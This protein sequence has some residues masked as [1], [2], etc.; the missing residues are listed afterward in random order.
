MRVNEGK[1]RHRLES[2]LIFSISEDFVN[3]IKDDPSKPSL[4]KN[5]PDVAVGL[6]SHTKT[7]IEMNECAPERC[8]VLK[9]L[10]GKVNNPSRWIEVG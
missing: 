2:I 6:L 8:G 4:S 1:L 7:C 5:R 9:V 10:N 3:L